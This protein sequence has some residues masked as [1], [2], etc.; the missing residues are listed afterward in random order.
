[1]DDIPMQGIMARRA[2]LRDLVMV[3][4]SR[5]FRKVDLMSYVLDR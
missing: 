4:I 2:K 5:Q 1:M 3:G